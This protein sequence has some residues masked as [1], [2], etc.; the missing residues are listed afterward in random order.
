M[1]RVAFSRLALCMTASAATMSGSAIYARQ[2][3][4]AAHTV[5]FF[6]EGFPA[7]DTSVSSRAQLTAGVPDA[8]FAS[9]EELPGLLA[10]NN[11]GSAAS[12]LV[13][14]FGSAFPEN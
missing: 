3:A 11:A 4:P 12:L 8:Q 6:E 9:A 14:P 13:F 7:S 2:P 5:V 10:P 1:R